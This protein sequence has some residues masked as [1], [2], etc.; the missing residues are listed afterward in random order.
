MG[1]NMFVSLFIFSLKPFNL[2]SLF[3][4]S[5]LHAFISHAFESVNKLEPDTRL[6]S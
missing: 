4:S 3:F 6:G 5:V 2:N 1:G